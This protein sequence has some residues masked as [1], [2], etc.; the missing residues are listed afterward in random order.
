MFQQNAYVVWHAQTRGCWL[1]DPGFPPSPHGLLR[2][3]EQEQLKPELILIT[4][5]HPDH[6][7]GVTPLRQRLADVPIAA[8]R[9]EAAWLTDPQLNLSAAMQFPVTAPPAE[10]L[11]DPGD[12]LLLGELAF[13]ARD[14]SGHSPGGLAFHCAAAGVVLVGDA[15]FAGSIGRYDFPGSSRT[16]LLANIQANLLS[17]PDETVVYSGHGPATTIG[18]ERHSNA[19]LRAELQDA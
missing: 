4:H 16:R 13:V 10:R 19:V 6:I 18:R 5:A 1:V 9:V 15:L 7:A 8:P 3:V 2:V 14:V 12:T 11:I 17:L